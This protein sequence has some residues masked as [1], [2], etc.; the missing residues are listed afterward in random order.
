MKSGIGLRRSA[1][2]LVIGTVS[3]AGCN[4]GNGSGIVRGRLF[5]QNCEH[6]D[7]QVRPLGT[8]EAPEPYAMDPEFLSGEPLEDPRPSGE[9]RENR[10]IIRL[11]STRRGVDFTDTLSLQVSNSYLVAQCV[12]GRM[13]RTPAGDLK[14]D[15]DARLCSWGPEGQ[16]PARLRVGPDFPIRANLAPRVTC[17][18]NNHVVATAVG[19]EPKPGAEALTPDKWESWIEITEFGGAAS[20]NPAEQR[21][22]ISNDFKVNFDGRI[23]VTAFHLTLTDDLVLKSEKRNEKLPEPDIAGELTGE[24]DFAMERGQGYQAFP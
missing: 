1:W 16:G 24:F 12:R 15:Y 23:R 21:A 6:R 18:R 2:M 20:A 5:V 7:G 3:V 8:R 19:R 4:G 17:P 14:P 10:L 13:I 9:N 22:A 11:Q